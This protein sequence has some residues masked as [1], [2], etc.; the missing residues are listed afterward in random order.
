[1]AGSLLTPLIQNDSQGGAHGS[2]IWRALATDPALAGR[3]HCDVRG[4]V[5][6]TGR[7]GGAAPRSQ[8]ERRRWEL[9]VRLRL[10]AELGETAAA[11]LEIRWAERPGGS[12]V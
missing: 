3:V 10:V 9:H 6:L 8:K 12:G 5:V 4:A 11:A 2:D 7:E 1:M